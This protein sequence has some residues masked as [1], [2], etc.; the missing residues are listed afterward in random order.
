MTGE[1]ALTR[2]ILG[3][4]VVT[5]GAQHPADILMVGGRIA[6]VGE[7][8][9]VNV[10]EVIDASGMFVLPGGVDPHTHIN[11]TYR[12]KGTSDDFASATTA[13]ACGGTSCVID[14]CFPEPGQ[15]LCEAL[16]TWRA[17]LDAD[18][19]MVDVGTHMVLIDPTDEQLAEL[20]AVRAQ[21]VTS[22]KLF[23]AYKGRTMTRDERLFRSMQAAAAHDMLVLV[24]AENGD[25]IDALVRDAL[26][27]G[28][29]TP[30]WH[31]STRPPATEGEAVNRA[32]EFAGLAG[33]DL[34]VV[35]V[36]CEEALAP[37]RR[38]RA[39]GRAVWAETCPQYLVLDESR[40]HDPGE[41]AARFVCT[42]PLRD[43]AQHD[44]LWRGLARDELSVL[45][46]DHCPFDFAKK[47][48]KADFTQILNGLPGI[49]QRL[50]LGH[51]Y[52]VRM[53]HLDMRRL[54]EI[55][56]TNPARLF[57]LHPRKGTIAPGADADVVV[58]DPERPLLITTADHH[59]RVDHLPYEGLE[60]IGAPRDVFV[61]GEAV[62]VDGR[63][64]ECCPGRF[65]HRGITGA[66]GSSPVP[67][68]GIA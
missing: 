21:G 8:G 40:L 11:G 37:I 67:I 1:G 30:R 47:W 57:G 60:V 53:G 25:V 56:S 5:A 17:E 51:H 66:A 55:T 61:R 9:A 3:G 10:D 63:P 39:R 12:N 20:A 15:P 50:L 13:A 42:P 41:I 27:A 38:A 14:F 22:L 49:E 44:V 4:T 28:H 52:G 35:H 29:V 36:T 33:C 65:A 59:S 7:L 45:A 68:G 18:S 48:P 2:A 64:R 23:M 46:T 16:A 32:I 6:A 58:F 24:H 19:L 43:R 34:Y 62:V 26:S 54:V 31:A